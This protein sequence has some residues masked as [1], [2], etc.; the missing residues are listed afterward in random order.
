MKHRESARI[1]RCCWL[2]L[3]L[4]VGLCLPGAATAQS[5]ARNLQADVVAL[6]QVFFWNRLGAVQP[7]GMMFA[8][9]RDV[10][11]TSG[12]TTLTAGDVLG[13]G[14]RRRHAAAHLDPR[15]WLERRRQP[16]ALGAGA[17]RR[18]GDLHALCRQGGGACPL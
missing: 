18:P 16:F 4:V 6:D 2:A 9:R 3:T 11:S 5:C 10:V 15:R 14:P 17:A 8:L 13:L 7:Q 12:G 1:A